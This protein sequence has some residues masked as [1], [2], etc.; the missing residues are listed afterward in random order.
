M[1]V[2]GRQ[3]FTLPLSFLI[4]LMVSPNANL[5]HSL[6][7]VTILRKVLSS[8]VWLPMATISYSMYLYHV[9]FIVLVFMTTFVY[10]D[11]TKE[12]LVPGMMK[13]DAQA[14][15]TECPWSTAGSY[16]RL[17]YI[18]VAG[19]IPTILIS[20]ISYLLVEKPGIDARRVFKSKY[21]KSLT[22]C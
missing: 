11:W 12:A 13:E 19:L 9:F 14:K 5:M 1:I 18:I 20:I 10:P 15:I 8:P 3:L 17:L 16:I 21:D 2:F 6:R 7:P 4:Y 22:D